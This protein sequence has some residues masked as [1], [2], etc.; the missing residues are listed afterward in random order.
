MKNNNWLHHKISQC[1]DYIV[2]GVILLLCLSYRLIY[3][4]V[5]HPGMVLYNSD[6]VSY[7]FPVDIFRGV[8]DL[9]RT[10][11]YPYIIKFFE[12]LSKDNLVQNLIL[13]QQMVSFL[14]V[15]PF[16]FVSGRIV[17]NRYLVILATLFYGVWHPVIIQNVHINPE[18]LCFAGS[19]FMLFILIKYVEKP[20]ISAAVSLGI[21]PFILIMLKPTYLILLLVILLF[22]LCRFV[23]L[24]E[25]RR[26]LYWGLLGVMISSAGVLGYC[27]LNKRHNGQFVLSN[28]PLNNAIV[29]ISQS[30]AYQYGGDTEFIAIVD[31]NRHL[32]YYAAPFIINNDV[33]DRYSI[34][35]RRF[36]PSLP[37]TEDMLFCMSIKDIANYP[38]ERIKRFVK[39]SQNTMIYFQYM[40]NRVKDITLAYGSIF[41]LFALQF[42]IVA[43]VFMKYK[44]IAWAQ[45]FCILFVLGQF[46]SIA[47]AGLDDMDRHLIPSYPFIIQIAASFMA[48]LISFLKKDKI[49]EAIA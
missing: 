28:I 25:E 48:V 3:F 8:V 49:V 40:V 6:S 11:L 36:P 22:L 26:I 35:S 31:A 38:P 29:R 33:I 30:G 19:T 17:K 18:S 21:F 5:L 14:S 10:P 43:G 41:I 37:P 9:Y 12:S 16:Y 24:R 15:M 7:F 47:I 46:F 34:S 23:F 20:R 39:N 13:F 45:A 27:E 44:K 42:L 2:L 32:G 1:P 4:G